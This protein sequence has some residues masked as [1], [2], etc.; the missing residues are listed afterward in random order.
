MQARVSLFTLVLLVVGQGIGQ[1]SSLQE[2]RSTFSILNIDQDYYDQLLGP[3]GDFHEVVDGIELLNPRAQ[4]SV[5][6]CDQGWNVATGTL[7]EVQFTVGNETEYRS[8]II[9]KSEVLS[10]DDTF[11]RYYTNRELGIQ[12]VVDS[13]G[14]LKLVNFVPTNQ[15]ARRCKNYP[16]Y[17][18]AVSMY[19]PHSTVLLARLDDI[20]SLETVLIEFKEN[21]YQE[22]VLYVFVY[23][24]TLTGSLSSSQLIEGIFR[25]IQVRYKHLE[26]RIHVLA[27]GYREE[28]EAEVFLIPK[29][30]PGPIARPSVNT[31][32]KCY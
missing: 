14:Y 12:V 22:H 6:N 8:G 15:T 4:F 24:N 11:Q 13:R 32:G 25:L 30:W 16:P 31:K 18:S 28:T 2:L 3:S 27:G 29:S 26:R 9:G 7:L 10:G 21:T 5:T 20:S 23:N 1:C 17:D 19:A